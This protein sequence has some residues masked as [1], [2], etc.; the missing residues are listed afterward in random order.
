MQHAGFD[1]SGRVHLPGTRHLPPAVLTFGLGI[2]ANTAI[3]YRRERSAAW[4]CPTKDRARL[5]FRLVHHA[6]A[7]RSADK[8]LGGRRRLSFANGAH[9]NHVF[10]GMVATHT[11]KLQLR[12]PA[13]TLRAKAAVISPETFRF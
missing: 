13:K 3:F 8:R 11:E 2:G 9:A 1:V 12:F 6:F 5:R 4:S 7:G 10:E